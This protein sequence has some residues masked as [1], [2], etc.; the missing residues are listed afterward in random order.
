MGNNHRYLK[1]KR[2]FTSLIHMSFQKLTKDMKTQKS[3]TQT[4]LR[5]EIKKSILI[6]TFQSLSHRQ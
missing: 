3:Q 1:R 6:R 5:G 4:V 2:L